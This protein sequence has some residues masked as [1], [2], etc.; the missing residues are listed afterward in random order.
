MISIAPMPGDVLLWWIAVGIQSFFYVFVFLRL[1][2]VRPVRSLPE[3]MPPVSVIICARNEA[4]NLLRFLKIVLIQQYR[5]YEVIVVNDRSTDNT[6]E[7]LSEYAG[8]NDNLRVIRIAAGTEKK[9][10]GK[11]DALLHGVEAAQYDTLVFTDADCRPATTHW[12]AKLVGCYMHDTEIVIGYAPYEKRPTFLNKLIRYENMMSAMLYLGFA[13]AGLPYMGTGRN[14][15]YKKHVIRNFRGFAAK[16]HLLS[17][18]DDLVVNHAARYSNTEI[19]IDKDAFVYSEAKSTW[20]EWLQQKKRHLRTAIS[21]KWFHATLLFLFALSQFVFYTDFIWITLRYGLSLHI[22]SAAFLLLV[23]KMAVTW[24]ISKKLD[25]HDL[26]LIIPLLDILY[27]GY[28][29]L[30]FFLLLLRPKDKWT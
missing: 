22:L 24:R 4:A 19:C 15:S 13:K 16:P 18:D 5:Q 6:D 10:P 12:L 23:F 21:Y 11:K 28:L 27:T 17:G 9:L 1:N 30:I 8:R 7:V 14:L 25:N 26:W 29:L 3:Q 2:F 20:S